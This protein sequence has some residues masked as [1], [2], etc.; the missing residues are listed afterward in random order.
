MPP[1]RDVKGRPTRS[2]VERHE[3]GVPNEPEV[4]TQ[5][6]VI[7]VEFCEA[8]QLLREDVTN[9]VGQHRE[10]REKVHN[11][12]RISEFLRMKPPCFSCSSVTDD[13]QN[14]IENLD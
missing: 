12:L 10:N 6:K 7:N 1:R 11:T 14:S 2:N 5:G 9:Q 8:I 13:L 3:Q 4:Q